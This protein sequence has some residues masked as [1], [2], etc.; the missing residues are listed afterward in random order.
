MNAHNKW[1]RYLRRLILASLLISSAGAAPGETV[2]V[3]SAGSLRGVVGALER[4]AQSRWNLEAKPTF[5]GSGLLRE[6]IEKGQR[7]D[8]FLSADLASSLKL[9]QQGRTVVPAIARNR[10]CIVSR[11]ELTLTADNL[12]DRLLARGVRIRTS[13]PVADPCGNYAWAIF[14]RIERLR[15]AAGATLQEKAQASMS[16]PMKPATPEQNPMAA[17]FNSHQVDV[18][19]SYCSGT[20]ALLREAQ[21][22]ESLVVPA[23]LD[24]HPIDGMAVL[25]DRPAVLRL[26]LWLLSEKGQA[27][28]AEQEL[29]PLREAQR[30]PQ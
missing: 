12:I 27:A 23:A 18:A 3:Y 15:P 24:P 6:R 14:D 30:A 4:E 8:L 16:L 5:G 1:P 21:Q 10:M 13:T 7:P 22:V 2:E 11:R 29:V 26:A 17:L 25:A 19:I 28:V 9:E 20:A